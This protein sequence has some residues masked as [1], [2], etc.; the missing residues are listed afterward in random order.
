[1][2]EVLFRE[3]HSETQIHTHRD[4]VDREKGGGEDEKVMN[5]RRPLGNPLL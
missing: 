5:L 4:T 3:E 2:S 1:M